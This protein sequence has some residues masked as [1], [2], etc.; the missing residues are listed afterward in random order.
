MGER[1]QIWSRDAYRAHRSAQRLAAREGL[2]ELRN[3][4]RLAR[5][6]SDA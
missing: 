6:G 1:F 4:Q 3:R 5:T 2:I